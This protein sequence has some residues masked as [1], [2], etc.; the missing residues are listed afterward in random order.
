MWKNLRRAG[1]KDD[2]YSMKTLD[3]VAGSG[4][5]HV[6]RKTLTEKFPFSVKIRPFPV[7]ESQMKSKYK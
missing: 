5:A 3:V 1:T 6:F 7:L 2:K 4:F